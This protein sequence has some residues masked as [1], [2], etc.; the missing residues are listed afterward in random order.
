[1]DVLVGVPHVPP[2]YG[3]VAQCKVQVMP[4]PCPPDSV[5]PDLYTWMETLKLAPVVMDV[6]DPPAG[7]I[8]PTQ[9]NAAKAGW[10]NKNNRPIRVT[11]RNEIRK[12][13]FRFI[14]YHL[15]L[16]GWDLE[17]PR[18]EKHAI[19]LRLF[20]HETGLFNYSEVQG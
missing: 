4:A 8:P 7:D 1:M 19:K 20:K 12:K 9:P 10:T 16:W 6:V 14:F 11:V 5:T 15:W 17:G 18:N 2:K 13:A 3:T